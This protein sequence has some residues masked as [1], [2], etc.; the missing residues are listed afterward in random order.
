[1]QPGTANSA[2]VAKLEHWLFFDKPVSVL[3]LPLFSALKNKTTCSPIQHKGRQRD[4]TA[5]AGKT[6]PNTKNPHPGVSRDT[7]EF[8]CSHHPWSG[9]QQHQDTPRCAVQ[10]AYQI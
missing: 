3:P 1:M 7:G 9:W 10:H 8:H 5:K 2:M 4:K 6:K